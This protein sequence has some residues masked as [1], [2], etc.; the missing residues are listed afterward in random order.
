MV[1]ESAEVLQ[2]SEGTAPGLQFKK[3]GAEVF[4]LPGVPHEMRTMIQR[5]LVPFVETRY[6]KRYIKQRLLRTTGIPESSLFEKIDIIESITRDVDIA[7]LPSSSGVNMR[8]TARGENE[9]E[10]LARLRN[11]EKQL[12]GKTANFIYG[13]D[14]E[15]LEQ[16]VAELLF[17]SGK[18]IAVAE[19]CTGGLLA[20][21]L[22]SISGS[23][24]YFERG[25]VTYSNAAKQSMLDVPEETLIEHGAVSEDTAIA[26]AEGVRKL[27]AVDIGISTTGIAGP[28]GGTE[29][30]PVGL[31]FI[32]FSDGEIAR[33]FRFNFPFGRS[34]NTHRSVTAALELLRRYLLGITMIEQY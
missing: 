25:L 32:G 7:F 22:T 6:S 29:V 15:V 24:R 19:S 9:Q 26:M 20:H 34:M 27:A 8:I 11:A 23:S 17:S 1:P 3:E 2:N 4:V 21:K 31:V 13:M 28:T 18:T 16:V 12:R 14:D 33:A 30:K 5:Y 10:C